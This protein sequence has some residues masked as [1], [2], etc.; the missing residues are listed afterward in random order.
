MVPVSK[1]KVPWRALGEDPIRHP[2]DA[3]IARRLKQNKLSPARQADPLTWLRRATF[4]LTGLAPTPDEVAAHVA[5]AADDPQNAIEKVISFAV[6][7]TTLSD[8]CTDG[9]QTTITTPEG[10]LQPPT[11]NPTG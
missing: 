9:F 11:C 5:D 6:S 10:T 7:F 1:P 4:D 3:F 8:P 2:V